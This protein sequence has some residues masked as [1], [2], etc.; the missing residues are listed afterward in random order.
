MEILAVIVLAIVLIAGWAIMATRET[1]SLNADPVQQ[2]LA[3]Y[4]ASAAISEDDAVRR[5][6]IRNVEDVLFERNYRSGQVS[7]RL[8]H[9]CS[10]IKLSGNVV[11]YERAKRIADLVVRAW[12]NRASRG[13]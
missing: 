2:V 12:P 8:A 3:E 1:S 11:V 13:S 6:L 10:M 5:G 4:L 9:A 7:T